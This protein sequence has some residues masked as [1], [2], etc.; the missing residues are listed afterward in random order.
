MGNSTTIFEVLAN[1]TRVYVPDLRM[2]VRISIENL[3]LLLY[4]YSMQNTSRPTSSPAASKFYFFSVFPW[5]LQNTCLANIFQCEV[6]LFSVFFNTD[7]DYRAHVTH[8]PS[9]G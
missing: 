2:I 7:S 3:Q 8:T 4:F 9:F 1:Q 6:Q 5:I